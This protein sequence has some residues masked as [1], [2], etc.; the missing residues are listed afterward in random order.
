ML[1][2]DNLVLPLIFFILLRWNLSNFFNNRSYKSSSS[3]FAILCF[4]PLSQIWSYK[5]FSSTGTWEGSNMF[6]GPANLRKF[7][8]RKRGKSYSKDPYFLCR[9]T[10]RYGIELRWDRH[11]SMR[12][13]SNLSPFESLTDRFIRT[14]LRKHENRKWCFNSQFLEQF[15]TIIN[16]VSQLN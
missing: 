3:L 15:F 16:F 1:A 8:R 14:P 9:K 13:L 6:N 11:L 5:F 7:H 12:I 2:S 10:L 4:L